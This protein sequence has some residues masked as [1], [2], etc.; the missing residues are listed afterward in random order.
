MQ[1]LM[2][3]F[4]MYDVEDERHGESPKQSSGLPTAIFGRIRITPAWR[5]LR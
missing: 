4:A 2:L 3:L 1:G 5:S